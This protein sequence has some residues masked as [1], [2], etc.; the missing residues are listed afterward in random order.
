MKRIALG[1]F[2]VLLFGSSF[3]L[4]FAWQEHCKAM[5]AESCRRFLPDRVPMESESIQV[6]NKNSAGI[7]F[8]NQARIAIAALVSSGLSKEMQQKYQYAFVSEAR[9][10]LDRWSIPAGMVGLGPGPNGAQGGQ[11][12]ALTARDFLGNEIETIIL[13]LDPNATD[14]KISMTPKGPAAFELRIGKY[15]IQGTQR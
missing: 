15:V 3:L 10:R 9:V 8:P 12:L 4:L 2:V 7:Q 14:D 11:T 5:D 6:D 13:T 1:V